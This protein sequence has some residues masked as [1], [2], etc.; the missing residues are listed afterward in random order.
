MIATFVP[1]GLFAAPVLGL[2]AIVFG[3]IGLG[4]ARR[5]GRP[6]DQAI[7]GIVLGGVALATSLTAIWLFRHVFAQALHEVTAASIG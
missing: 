7:I 1:P 2:L 3:A 5:A 4:R 6:V